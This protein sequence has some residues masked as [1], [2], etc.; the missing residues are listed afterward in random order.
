[1]G[2]VGDTATT[3]LPED[4]VTEH[5]ALEED[6]SSRRVVVL[7]EEVTEML[8][9]LLGHDVQTLLDRREVEREH[10]TVV[11]LAHLDDDL[12][13]GIERML[14]E[15]VARL[16]RVLL[17]VLVD[18]LA[19]GRLHLRDLF[20]PVVGT[21]LEGAY[22]EIREVAHLDFSLHHDCEFL[23]A[24]NEDEYGPTS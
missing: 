20:D 14:I 8:G 19:R 12:T 10:I 13:T 9:V 2:L 11:I 24:H 7:V 23:F 22:Q 3:K 4:R 21:A 16:A 15:R 1:M 5:A 17:A 18:E 6:I